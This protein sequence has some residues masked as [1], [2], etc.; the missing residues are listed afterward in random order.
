MACWLFCASQS[1][2]DLPRSAEYGFRSGGLRSS[3]WNMSVHGSGERILAAVRNLTPVINDFRD[4]I[5]QT[6][7]LPKALVTALQDAEIFRMWLPKALGGPE[8]SIAE[9][10]HIVEVLSYLE[11]SV[12]WCSGIGAA[13]SRFAGFLAPTTAKQIFDG[14]IL[15]GSLL[16]TGR[17][18]KVSGATL[19][20]ADGRGPA[21][22]MHST[23]MIAAFTTYVDDKPLLVDGKPEMRIGFF[24]KSPDVAVIDTW[25]VGGLRG[26]PAVMTSRCGICLFPT[27]TR[28]TGWIHLPAIRAA[29][30]PSR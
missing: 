24:P 29:F 18:R 13:Y 19:L 16:P 14:N 20:P 21:G 1:L 12:G 22:F 17:G 11:G 4:Q 15:A 6:R 30:M 9:Y 8:L 3:G 28:L 27:S 5:E 10:C 2:W 23:W 7:G 26:V 25:N